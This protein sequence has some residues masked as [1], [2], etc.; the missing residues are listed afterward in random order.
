M[1]PTCAEELQ[2]QQN[3]YEYVHEGRVQVTPQIRQVVE[4]LLQVLL[5]T[6]SWS[7]LDTERSYILLIFKG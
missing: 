6:M 4:A 7:K 5:V 3:L 1:R 2:V